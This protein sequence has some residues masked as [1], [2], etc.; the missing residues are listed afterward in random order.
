MVEKLSA[1]DAKLFPIIGS[2]VLGGLYLLFKYMSADLLNL[3]LGLYF[4]LI[5]GFS[6]GKYLD[7][8]FFTILGKKL[9]NTLFPKWRLLVLKQKDEQIR[10]PFTLSSIFF[11]IVSLG[12]ST[13]YLLFN[14]PWYLN[15]FLGLSFAFTGIKLIELDSVAT[16]AILLTGLFFYDIFWVFF[17]PVMVSVAKGLEAPIKLV[18]PK[19]G[20]L[21]FIAVLTDKLGFGCPCLQKFLTNDD[22]SFTLLGLGDI[23]LPG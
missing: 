15:N 11:L 17:T 22:P 3:L 21:G 23:V 6:G 19:D 10:F 12:L 9:Y 7:A 14:R 13:S 1:G 5:G 2:C 16:G 4:S 20:G 8:G 18:W